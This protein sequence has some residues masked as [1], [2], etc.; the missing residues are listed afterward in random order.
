MKVSRPKKIVADFHRVIGKLWKNM[1]A[2]GDKLN[3]ADT[4]FI[5]GLEKLWKSKDAQNHADFVKLPLKTGI[6]RV[7]RPKILHRS[8]P[9]GTCASRGTI[10]PWYVG[11]QEDGKAFDDAKFDLWCR[12][13]RGLDRTQTHAVRL[14]A[15]ICCATM[16]VYL[17][18]WM[19]SNDGL[20]APT[21][22]DSSRT[23]Y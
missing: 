16:E 8:T 23:S 17:V 9:G 5:H 11:V 6:V 14:S 1:N 12:R 18:E 19:S 2:R 20:S 3:N 7:A 15:S 4:A 22:L 21:Q 13:A 10:L